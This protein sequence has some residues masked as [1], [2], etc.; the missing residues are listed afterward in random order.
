L[1]ALGLVLVLLAADAAYAGLRFRSDF[2][3]A[4][5]N[6][7]RAIDRIQEFDVDRGIERLRLAE[8]LVRSSRGYLGHPAVALGGYL[9]FVSDDVR[10]LRAL[11]G[12]AREAVAA[13]LEGAD[14]AETMGL[15]GGSLEALYS[16]GRV[17]LG[18]LDVAADAL[19]EGRARVDRA[20][21]IISGAPTP[22]IGQ[23]RSAFSSASRLIADAGQQLDS[24]ES[25]LRVLPDVLGADGERRYLLAFQTPSEARAAGGLIGVYGVLAVADGGLELRKVAPIR[26]L[27]PKLKREVTG[28]KWFDD[29]YG[30]L[31]SL[32]EWRNANQSPT[33]STVATVLLRMYQA[34][35]GA[36]LDGVI[37]MDPFVVADLTRGTGT[38]AA[39]G[40]DVEVGPDNAADVLLR[41]IYLEFEGREDEQNAYLRDLVDELWAKMGSGEVDGEEL[42]KGLAHSIRTQHLKFFSRVPSDRAALGAAGLTGDPSHHGP[43]VQMV[44][45]NNFAA[46]KVDYFLERSQDVNVVISENGDARIV[47]TVELFNGAPRGERSLLKKSDVND[48]PSGLNR[49]SLHFMLPERATIND[50]FTG[51]RSNDYFSGAE[52][53]RFPVA[54]RLVD[55]Q[56]QET[57]QLAVSYTVEDMV[58][59]SDGRGRF[60]MTLMPQVLV[61]PDRLEM[62]VVAPEGYRIGPDRP[63]APYSLEPFTFEGELKAPRTFSLNLIA[64]GARVPSETNLNRTC[65]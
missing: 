39:E 15:A 20:E 63:G 21:A 29:L 4:A 44:F 51:G 7:K 1:V 26:N 54:W 28:P 61:T 57:V 45:H 49:M 37:A 31:S 2:K 65:T 58:E 9:P 42:A 55:I 47:T 8:D 38:I 17:R 5:C 41:D 14:A 16:G 24:A 18:A 32:R 53:D 3:A 46:N 33:F 10:A 25:L 40:L 30:N 43:N 60:D 23:V 64:P 50:F 27:V 19:A 59:F 12:V 6:L 13:G 52:E 62:R 34:S 22:S 56:V 35:V 36:R 48:L 11:T